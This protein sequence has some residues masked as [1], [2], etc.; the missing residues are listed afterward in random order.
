MEG[1]ELSVDVF[2]LFLAMLALIAVA[3]MALV[4]LWLLGRIPDLKAAWEWLKKKAMWAIAGLAS[5]AML[6]VFLPFSAL[7]ALLVGAGWMLGFWAITPGGIIGIGGDGNKAGQGQTK[8]D[9]EIKVT[10]K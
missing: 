3:I 4:M 1:V 9:L 7:Y 6:S 10:S 2:S 5:G 8:Y